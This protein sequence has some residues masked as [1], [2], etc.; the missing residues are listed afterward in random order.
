MHWKQKIM[1]NFT[2]YNEH[3]PLG[4]KVNVAIPVSQSD[5]FHDWA[6]IDSIDE[7]LV[8]LQLSRDELPTGVKLSAGVILDVRVGSDDKGYSCRGIIV[9]EG[10]QRKIILRFIGEIVSNEL[11]EFYRIDAF[12]PIRYFITSEQSEKEM[13]ELWIAK[14][15]ARK[16]LELEQHETET[17]PWQRLRDIKNEEQSDLEA[18]VGD[19]LNGNTD[20]SK[21]G[22]TTDITINDNWDDLVPLA[23]NISGGG[24][25]VLLH[26]QFA[27]DELVPVEILLPE[28]KHHKIIDAVCKTVFSRENVAASKQMN[29]PSFNTAFQF[30][31]IDE[32]ERDA[33]VSY[34]SNVQLKRIRA[35]REQYLFRTA[36][37]SDAV[38]DPAQQKRQKVIQ[39]LTIIFG[40]LILLMLVSY[41]AR[42]TEHRPQSEIERIFDQ[43]FMEYLRK[44]GRGGH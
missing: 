43:G 4:K 2:S 28:D 25:R 27:E 20:K 37:T 16:K 18:T 7:D 6:I 8:T 36:G 17:K 34:I 3:F 44:I 12:L 41:F 23:A 30:F 29:R 11:R 31:Y 38:I 33:L 39:L 24:I 14:R 22:K 42:Y 5:T 13:K 1:S 32:R 15:E 10:L 35:M 40:I 26:H 19:L 21:A 9:A